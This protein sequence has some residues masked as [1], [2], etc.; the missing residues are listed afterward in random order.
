VFTP[1]SVDRTARAFA[2]ASLLLLWMTTVPNGAEAQR[3]AIVR[4]R[5]LAELTAQAQT[6]VVVRVA[7]A[8]VEPHP[9]FKNLQTVVVNV[10]VS[11]TLKGTPVQTLTFRQFIWDP[12]DIDDK[13]A[14]VRGEELL[15]FLNAENQYGLTSPAGLNQGRFVIK[16]DASGKAYAVNGHGN[17]DLFAGMAESGIA[18]RMSARSRVLVSTQAEGPI[19]LGDLRAAILELAAGAQQ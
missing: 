3:G 12:R 9:E 5:N 17:Q 6:I 1:A 18:G 2:A 10:T 13:A 16:R 11:D 7:F 4:S 8:R 15:L 14:Y 19:P